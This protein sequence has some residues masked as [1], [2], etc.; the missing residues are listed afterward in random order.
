MALASMAIPLRHARIDDIPALDALIVQSARALCSPDYTDAQIEAAIGSAWGVDSELIRDSTYYVAE[1]GGSIV[2]CGGWSF[3][4]TLFGGD[5]QAGRQSDVLD[6]VHDAA[7]V[8]AF[9]VHPGAAR[10]GIGRALLERCEAD[11]R[12]HGFRAAE[13]VAT[14]PG[15][16]LYAAYGYVGNKRIAYP[17]PG[18]LSID[19]V[20]MRKPLA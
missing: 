17:L 5:G 8:R 4:K 1:D 9:F 14:L 19:F 20:P 11:A 15:R 18:G 12:A 10:R 6:P 3:R 7:R 2:A 16:R 13:L